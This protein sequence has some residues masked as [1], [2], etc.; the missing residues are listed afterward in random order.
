[1]HEHYSNSSINPFSIR[2]GS[3]LCIDDSRYIVHAMPIQVE[4][5]GLTCK[6]YMSE[7]KPTDKTTIS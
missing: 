1:M 3:I 7:Y 4:A 2:N 5:N 6:V